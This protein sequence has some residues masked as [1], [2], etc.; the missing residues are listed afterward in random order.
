MTSLLT[1]LWSSESR[2]NGN[3]APA[4]KEVETSEEKAASTPRVAELSKDKLTSLRTN[5]NVT[6]TPLKETQN[7]VFSP[8]T[9]NASSTGIDTSPNSRKTIRSL[10]RALTAL[11][12]KH[13]KLQN[14]LD[15]KA[16]DLETV[17]TELEA[18]KDEKKVMKATMEQLEKST[19]SELDTL[20]QEKNELAT[21]NQELLARVAQ[22]ER[23]L[24]EKTQESE[25]RFH[26]M[27][28]GQE[29][30]EQALDLVK[31]KNKPWWQCH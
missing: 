16:G 9:S 15:L 30:L 3:T 11:Q 2:G 12:Q 25:A 26:S 27:L 28:M 22:L 5:A 20:K 18:S 13:D 6:K 17:K 10:S 19:T 1:S 4:T 23:E 29:Q 8:K 31:R 14:E 24:C 7:V 21:L